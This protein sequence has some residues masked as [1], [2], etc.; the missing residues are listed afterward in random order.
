[1]VLITSVKCRSKMVFLIEKL[2]NLSCF[3]V[4]ALFTVSIYIYTRYK[5]QFDR[6]S[7]QLELLGHCC[8]NVQ[9]C[10]GFF[11]GIV[12]LLLLFQ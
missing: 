9:G 8:H 5:C 10:V 1:M 6:H 4:I 3:I 12:V 2:G 7:T 11:V